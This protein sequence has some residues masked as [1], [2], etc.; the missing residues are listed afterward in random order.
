MH[1]HQVSLQINEAAA[2][3]AQL[4][5]IRAEDREEKEAL[6]V[7]VFAEVQVVEIE[8]QV[9]AL[10]GWLR[11]KACRHRRHILKRSQ[12]FSYVLGQC[13]NLADWWHQGGIAWLIL[14]HRCR[15]KLLWGRWLRW[16]AC[17]H[18]RHILQRSLNFSYLPGQCEQA[19]TV[20]EFIL[21]L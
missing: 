8:V 2:A 17:R 15:W 18:T 21:F 3:E 14:M 5:R 4:V 16:K 11:W 1:L 10:V 7:E 19:V 20:Y 13:D 9:E 6:D 12:N